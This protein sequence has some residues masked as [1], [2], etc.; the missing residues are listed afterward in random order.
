MEGALAALKSLARELGASGAASVSPE[1][2]TIRDD[3]AAVCA[4]PRCPYYGLGASC[5]P[6]VPG[7]PAMRTW[8]AQARGVL[9]ARMDVPS[10]VLL[11]AQRKE[12]LSVL[13]ETVAAIEARARDLGFTRSRAFAGGSCKTMFCRG[14]ARCAVAEGGECRNPDRARPSM[15]GF[16]VDVEA[17]V[18]SAGW[19]MDPG[20][21]DG[22]ESMM[23]VFGMVLLA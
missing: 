3:L 6:H 4:N 21:G 10:A 17:M 16:G 19:P 5:P 9:V 18:H 14:H 8:L 13:H 11:S 7:P 1:S 20:P 2:V 15:S 23:S 22:G 12:V